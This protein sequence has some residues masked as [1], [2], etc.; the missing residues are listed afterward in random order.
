MSEIGKEIGWE[1]SVE[2]GQDFVLLPAGDYDFE[3][4]SFERGRY[5]GSDKVPACPRAF[6]KLRIDGPDGASTVISESLLLYDR[7][8]WKLAEFF[9]SIGAEEVDGRVKMNW[10]IVPR[11][12]G[13]ATIEVQPDRN[14]PNKKYNH[15]KKFLPK[16]K[17]EYKAGSF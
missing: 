15:V 3:V 14:D 12:T 7:M 9:L 6:L 5:E 8:Q 17:K 16:T 10:N 11:A 1:D 4:E 13:R 2:K